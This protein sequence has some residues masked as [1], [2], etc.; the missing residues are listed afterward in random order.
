MTQPF[1]REV[2]NPL[3]DAKEIFCPLSADAS[4]HTLT[5]AD[6]VAFSLFPSEE[7]L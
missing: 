1:R 5:P 2:Q 4:V 6:F 7:G 3:P